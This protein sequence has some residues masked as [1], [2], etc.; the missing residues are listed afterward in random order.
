MPTANLFTAQTH[1]KT[2]QFT[3]VHVHIDLVG[4]QEAGDVLA[5]FPQLLVPVGEILIRHLARDIE[6]LLKQEK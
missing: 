6:N 3:D 5:V 1:S 2:R 4:D